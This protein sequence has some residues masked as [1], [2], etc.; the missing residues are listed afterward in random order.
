[1]SKNDNGDE[2]AI[3]RL[4]EFYDEKGQKP[5]SDEKLAKLLPKE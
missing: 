2:F 5:P 4:K 1:M 3:K